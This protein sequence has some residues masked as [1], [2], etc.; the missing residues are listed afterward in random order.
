MTRLFRNG[1]LKRKS[2]YPSTKMFF[3]YRR[4]SEI[5]QVSGKPV[6]KTS[7]NGQQ[8]NI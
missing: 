6:L 4:P 8:L 5:N 7:D 2:G 3:C 1:T